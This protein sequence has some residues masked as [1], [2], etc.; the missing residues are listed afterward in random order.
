MLACSAFTVIVFNTCILLHV[1]NFYRMGK[2]DYK[3]KDL[4]YFHAYGVAGTQRINDDGSE[5]LTYTSILQK[6]DHNQVHILVSLKLQTC[7]HGNIQCGS[8][9]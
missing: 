8:T 3:R 5:L 4:N 6:L 7:I 1:F 2:S 9:F